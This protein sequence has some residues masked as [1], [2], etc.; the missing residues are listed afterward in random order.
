MA[1]DIDI[2]KDSL[3][4]EQRIPVS[5]PFGGGRLHDGTELVNPL[6]FMRITR[7]GSDASSE[8]WL[9]QATG[10]KEGIPARGQRSKRARI[11]SNLHAARLSARGEH[12]LKEFQCL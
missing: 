12:A 5:V 11:A 7:L 2:P 4:K 3:A 10:L 8:Y 9:I 1:T 6:T